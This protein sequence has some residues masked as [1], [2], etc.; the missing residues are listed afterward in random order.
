MPT[1]DESFPSDGLPFMP[2]AAIPTPR[3]LRAGHAKS[4]ISLNIANAMF[5]GLGLVADV[6]MRDFREALF[7]FGFTSVCAFGLYTFTYPMLSG[8]EDWWRIGPARKDLGVLVFGLCSSIISVWA[9]MQS[10]DTR[11]R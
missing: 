6:Y 3:S 1:T 10:W 9:N 5:Y 8:G 7:S 2:T 4:L 11:L